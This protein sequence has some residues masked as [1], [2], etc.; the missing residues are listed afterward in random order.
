M[1]ASGLAPTTGVE[2]GVELMRETVINE[3][4]SNYSKIRIIYITF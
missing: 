4:Y 2:E 1:F 3:R